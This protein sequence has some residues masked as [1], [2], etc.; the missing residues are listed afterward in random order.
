ME[1]A[2]IG[3]GPDECEG[4][5]GDLGGYS[6]VSLA[7]TVCTARIAPHIAL[8]L[9][10][11]TVFAHA[12]SNAGGHPK[13]SPEPRVATFRKS[14]EATELPGLF[15][16]KIESTELQKLP[17]MS[18]PSQVSRFG[19]DRQ[20]RDRSNSWNAPQSLIILVAGKEVVGSFFDGGPQLAQSEEL[21]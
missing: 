14:G 15:G 13:D 12:Y 4:H 5:A 2:V 1:A 3:S 7:L 16:G 17:V 10:P 9:G 20:S 18:K 21:A 8:E 19:E 6:D 11:E